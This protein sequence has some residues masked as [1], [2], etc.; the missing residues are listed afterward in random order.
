MFAANECKMRP[1]PHL[2]FSPRLLAQV[3]GVHVQQLSLPESPSAEAQKLLD[4]MENGA[5]A[6]PAQSLRPQTYLTT[7]CLVLEKA[8]SMH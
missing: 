4:W 2:T 5:A 7:S 8:F 1:Q 6:M 3:G